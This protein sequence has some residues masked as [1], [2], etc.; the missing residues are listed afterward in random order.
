MKKIAT[1]IA[2]YGGSFDPVHIGHLQAI[3]YLSQNFDKVVVLLA[4]IS[5]FKKGVVASDEHRIEMLKLALN[6]DNVVL[7]CQ[8]IERPAPSYFVHSLS[9]LIDKYPNAEFTLC[10]GQDNLQ[11]L[12]KWKDWENIK[13]ICK[14]LVFRRQQY[15]CPFLNPTQ[16][17]SPIVFETDIIVPNVVLIGC[18]SSALRGTFGDS[19]KDFLPS[20]VY[21]YVV[22]KNLYDDYCQFKQA[23]IDKKFHLNNKRI[24]HIYRTVVNALTLASIYNLDC[25][26]VATAM[27]LHDIAKQ[28]SL[29][30]LQT[31]G[32]DIAQVQQLPPPLQHALSGRL[33][34]QKIFGINDEDILNAIEYHTTGRPMMQPIEMVVYL[35]DATEYGRLQELDEIGLQKDNLLEIIKEV[36]NA[37]LEYAMYLALQDSIQSLVR[38]KLSIHH[39]TQQA[40]EYYKGKL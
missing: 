9:N 12:P 5:P 23:L 25:N 21:D 36:N 7:D 22:E 2:I 27:Y 4:K 29:Q 19:L 40:L 1:Q 34:A 17:L 32:I 37:N 13:S 8:E 14:I 20:K 6:F 15:A 16:D 31:L 10:I 38:R 33:I 35:A 28:L 3:E 39:T 26:K 30:E 18:S 11:S 24:Q